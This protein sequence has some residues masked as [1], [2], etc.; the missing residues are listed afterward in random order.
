VGFFFPSTLLA[1]PFPYAHSLSFLSSYAPFLAHTSTSSKS[2][3]EELLRT[4]EEGLPILVGFMLPS[5]TVFLRPRSSHH[6]HNL[7]SEDPERRSAGRKSGL[8]SLTA[9]PH[10]SNLRNSAVPIPLPFHFLPFSSHPP[11]SLLSTYFPNITL[12]Q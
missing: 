10:L 5:L 1:L 7:G 3:W 8:K 12:T 4:S 9:H 2:K 6:L 11:L